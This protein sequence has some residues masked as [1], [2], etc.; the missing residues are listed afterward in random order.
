ML[1]RYAAYIFLLRAVSDICMVYLLWI[2]VYYLRFFSGIFFTGKGIPDFKNHLTLA[3]PISLI[4]YLA[5]LMTGLYQAKRMQDL[6][7]QCFDLL[8]ASLFA[9]LLVLAFFY[10]LQDSPYSRRLLLIFCVSLFFGVLVSHLLVFIVMRELRAR[11]INLRYYAVVG[12]GSSGQQLVRDIRQMAWMGLKCACFIDDDLRR[13]G[14]TVLGVPVYGPI[15]RLIDIVREKYFD[16]VYLALSGVGAQKVYPLLMKLQAEGVTIRIVPDWGDLAMISNMCV[17][18]IGSQ[19]LFS[20]ADSP[21]DGLNAILKGCFDR[22]VALILLVLLAV[23]MAIIAVAIKLTSKG[24]IFYRQDRMGMDQRVFP[25]LKFRTMVEQEEGQAHWTI[26]D[27][28]RKTK[29]G[30]FL[31]RTSLDELPQL[32]NVL[33]GHMS[34]VGPRPERPVFTKQFSEEYRKYHLRHKVKAGMTGW[35]QIHDLR[36][37]TSLRKRLLYDL[38]YVKNWSF[39][40]D[41]WILLCTPWHVLKGK[42]AY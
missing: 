4:C 8:K 23:P 19:V 26:Q 32:F 37:D 3:I 41:L 13:I 10:Y 29:I 35:A 39:G 7:V 18:E 6:F 28:P 27:D 9:G 5:F 20:A 17:I 21:L 42:N 11:N 15:D 25:I 2:G 22:V 16:E 1:R 31:R 33:M 36:G 34:L 38:Y 24:S 30:A 40:L 12:A 14:K